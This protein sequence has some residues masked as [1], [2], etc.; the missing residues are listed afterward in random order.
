ME[1]EAKFELPGPKRLRVQTSEDVRRYLQ[2]QN[3][4]IAPFGSYEQH[5]AALPVS[6]DAMIAEA[7]GD[8]LSARTGILVT[9][10]VSLGLSA[11]H[12]QYPG[13][14]SLRPDTYVSLVRDILSALIAQGF[15]RLFLINAHF[16][17]SGVIRAV[18]EQLVC[19]ARDTVIVLRD[20]WNLP[21]AKQVAGQMFEEP[22]GHADAAD[23]S[24]MLKISPEY[25]RVTEFAADWPQVEAMVSP[26]LRTK[27]ITSTGII[28]S[29]QTKASARA[30]AAYFDAIVSDMVRDVDALRALA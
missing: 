8:A 25:V 24:L 22:G 13:T 30:G 3:V 11:F 4:V 27:Y 28:G 5:G 18:A 14:L 10:T 12:S 7:L 16:E 9:P 19:D 15:T 6:T 2:I 26:D 29:D 23:A 20:F 1:S 21:S 17:N